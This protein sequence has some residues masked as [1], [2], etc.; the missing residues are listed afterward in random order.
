M[1]AH[2]SACLSSPLPLHPRSRHFKGGAFDRW[3][4]GLI[5]AAQSDKELLAR[6]AERLERDVEV[7]FHSLS[8]DA[9]VR[10]ARQTGKDRARSVLTDQNEGFY[11]SEVYARAVEDFYEEA[12]GGR[13]AI[14]GPLLAAKEAAQG[15]EK[16]T[17]STGAAA[18][19]KK[20]AEDGAPSKPDVE[21][22]D[23]K[24]GRAGGEKEPARPP[25]LAEGGRW[26]LRLEQD[27]RNIVRQLRYE[28]GEKRKA[29]ALEAEEN[30][31]V[32]KGAAA[33]EAV[34]GE[35]EESSDSSES[36]HAPPPPARASRAKTPEANAHHRHKRSPTERH[37]GGSNSKQ[38]HHSPSSHLHDKKPSVSHLHDHYHGGH[39]AAAPPAAASAAAT[40]AS[41]SRLASKTTPFGNRPLHAPPPAP[42]GESNKIKPMVVRREG[43]QAGSASSGSNSARRGTG[44]PQPLGGSTWSGGRGGAPGASRVGAPQ[45][46]GRDTGAPQPL[47]GTPTRGSYGSYPQTRPPTMR[48]SMRKRP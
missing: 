29:E 30:A 18:E 19:E 42:F 8:S 6:Y 9:Q 46:L 37:G 12:L 27:M 20:P 1:R 22:A 17:A 47:G 23:A 16:G 41:S 5:A 28:I 25:W 45:P 44:L 4:R 43:D 40:G 7:W 35:T 13:K 32:A 36:E 10:H 24:A 21:M 11:G 3:K 33:A 14:S 31:E 26:R 15:G 2:R 38:S 39:A 34:P 48:D